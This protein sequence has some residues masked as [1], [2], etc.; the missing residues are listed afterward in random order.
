MLQLIALFRQQGWQVTFASAASGS[1]YMADL[2]AMD[3]EKRSIEMNN[4]SFDAF[5]RALQP[6]VVLFDRFMTE[7]Q[8]GW[9]I[10]TMRTEPN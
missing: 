7:E 4:E 9:R 3:V 6:S 10:Y 2:T 8:F 1:P 5:V